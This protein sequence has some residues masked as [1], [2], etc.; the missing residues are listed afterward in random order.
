M[1]KLIS[2]GYIGLKRCYLNIP[3]EEAK[4]RYQEDEEEVPDTDIIYEFE[5]DD[6][7]CAYDVYERT[8]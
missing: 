6:E 8:I 7:F 2:I 5:F 4:R 1:N 3:L